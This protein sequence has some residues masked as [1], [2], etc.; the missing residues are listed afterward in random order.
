MYTIIEDSGTQIKASVGDRL[1]LDIRELPESASAGGEIVL[2]RV[3]MIGG[4]GEAKI[5]T[6]YIE[7]AKVTAKVLDPDQK[8]EK[9]HVIK[10]KRRKGYR[11]KNGHRQRH[12]IVEVTGIDA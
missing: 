11:R 8:G 10:Y 2:D 7:G 9:I 1:S 3:L 6:P 12:L 4:E 5:G